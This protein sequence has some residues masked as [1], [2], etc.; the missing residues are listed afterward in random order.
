LN[1]NSISRRCS[2]YQA[3]PERKFG[4]KAEG[5][6][7]IDAATRGRGSRFVGFRECLLV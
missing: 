5:E 3:A 1:S 4:A 2:S 7:A 6:R